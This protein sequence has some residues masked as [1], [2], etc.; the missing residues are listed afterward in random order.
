[1]IKNKTYFIIP[2]SIVNNS[3]RAIECIFY[4]DFFFSDE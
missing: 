1:M 3:Y 4:F 2:V